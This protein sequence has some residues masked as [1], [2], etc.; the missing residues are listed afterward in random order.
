MMLRFGDFLGVVEERYKP[1]F[2]DY[3]TQEEL[4]LSQLAGKNYHV[5]SLCS[6]RDN[7]TREHVNRMLDICCEPFFVV[8]EN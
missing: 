8:D 5:V 6:S 1:S 3:L 7:L 2:I 4:D